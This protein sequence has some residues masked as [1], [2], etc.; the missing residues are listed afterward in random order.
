MWHDIVCC[1]ESQ[2]R[3]SHSHQNISSSNGDGDSE[4]LRVV[5]VPF[6]IRNS[7]LC[8][9]QHNGDKAAAKKLLDGYGVMSEPMRKALAKVTSV[10]VDLKPYYPLAGETAPSE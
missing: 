6:S 10:P 1:D 4:R 5:V 2:L 8:V 9:L 3:R 7:Y